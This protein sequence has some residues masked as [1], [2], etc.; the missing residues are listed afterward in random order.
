MDMA[1]KSLQPWVALLIALSLPGCLENNSGSASSSAQEEDDKTAEE[2]DDTRDENN[3]DLSSAQFGTGT[4]D[5]FEDGQVGFDIP[6]IAFEG[7]TAVRVT[8][9]DGE[10]HEPLEGSFQVEF[11]SSCVES[12]DATIASPATM[13]DGQGSTTY[14]AAGCTGEDEITATVQGADQTLEAT[15]TLEIANEALGSIVFREADPDSLGLRGMGGRPT[16]ADVTFQ[17]LDVA[18]RPLPGETVSFKLAS[19][20]G[21]AQLLDSQTTSDENGIV[22]ATVQA[23]TV[24][25]P[26]RVTA[27]HENTGLRSQSEQLSISTGIPESDGF[28]LSLDTRNPAAWECDGETVN[29]TIRARDRFS[30]P[31]IDGTRVHF[32]T[33]GGAI[34]PYCETVDGT[35]SVEWRS[36]APRPDTRRSSILAYTIGEE[37]FTDH[38]GNGLF[39][40]DEAA[41]DD[42]SDVSEPYRDDN[43]NETFTVGTDGFFFDFDKSGDWTEP[44]N[45]FDGVL[46][47]AGDDVCGNE[48]APLG[49]QAVIVIASNRVVD[50]EMV[51]A[52]GDPVT[53]HSIGDGPITARVSGPKN[54][55]LPEGTEVELDLGYGEV[56]GTNPQVVPST[57][58]EG[59]MEFTFA[60]K[61]EDEPGEAGATVEVKTPGNTCGE[62]TSERE[63]F[64]IKN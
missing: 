7:S 3:V 14:H 59:P 64:Q 37:S 11:T 24:P 8:V 51:N 15:A 30:H 9:V 19:E 47:Q 31:V 60:L 42:W 1:R 6:S 12:G 38:T 56:V 10:N 53:T 4:G 5:E 21:D 27:R 46:C 2:E 57:T 40:P 39:G 17:L 63:T 48:L 54:Q 43:E 49:K 26:V 29:V 55:P 34:E 44:N 52:D 13:R 25:Q 41:A 23:G 32:S 35:C 33:E 62:G 50:I 45:T 16:T 58:S 22:R 28:S 18:R 36:Q 61:A 20:V